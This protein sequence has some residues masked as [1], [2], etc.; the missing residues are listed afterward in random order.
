MDSLFGKSETSWTETVEVSLG[1]SASPAALRAG[2]PASAPE[3]APS[4]GDRF[5]IAQ[6]TDYCSAFA[7][8]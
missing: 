8:A 1:S 5:S 2:A 6:W 3:D 7:A 4:F